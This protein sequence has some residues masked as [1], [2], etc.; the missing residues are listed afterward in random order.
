MRLIID[1]WMDGYMNEQ[2]MEKACLEYVEEQLNSTAISAK[3]IKVL[4][5]EDIV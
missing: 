5:K 4:Y 1:I 3:I 2:D